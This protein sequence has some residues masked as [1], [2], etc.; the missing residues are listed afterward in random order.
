MLTWVSYSV[1][2]INIISG[3]VC[4]VFLGF[5]MRLAFESV[6]WV[7]KIAF[8][9]VGWPH[10][11]HH[12]TKKVEGY[13]LLL[14]PTYQL[15]WD[16][17]SC[18]L[19]V[20][21]SEAFGL[22]LELH[23]WLHQ[24]SNLQTTEG[25]TYQLPQ[26][27]KP[28]SQNKYLHVCR[29]YW[30]Y[31]SGEP[32]SIQGHV[33]LAPKWAYPLSNVLYLLNSPFCP[34]HLFMIFLFPQRRSMF[35]LWPIGQPGRC[36]LSEVS[37]CGRQL[38]IKSLFCTDCGRRNTGPLVKPKKSTDLESIWSHPQGHTRFSVLMFLGWEGLWLLIVLQGPVIH[39][40]I[41]RL[42]FLPNKIV[43]G[44]KWQGSLFIFSLAKFV[45]SEW[46]DE[47]PSL[48]ETQ[49]KEF[50]IISRVQFILE[51]TNK[52]KNKSKTLGDDFLIKY[53][54]QWPMK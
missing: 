23:H 31:F 20:K 34:S 25:E 1:P 24:A 32:R 43:H 50:D 27:H 19:G 30:S 22:R 18:P 54:K 28:V 7:E 8:P 17:D 41:K 10:P 38:W 15:S 45:P 35:I 26:S 14:L 9:M 36:A 37:E 52:P 51:K 40:P 21:D 49:L 33:G 46:S 4:R 47:G 5:W 11:I 12:P 48:Q 13:L 39:I 44:A 2:R 53:G 3:H 42:H 16:T 6:G 29:S